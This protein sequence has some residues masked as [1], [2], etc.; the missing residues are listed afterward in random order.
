VLESRTRNLKA[1]LICS[2]LA[3]AGLNVVAQEKDSDH[4]SDAFEVD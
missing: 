4:P 1:A 2:T 3:I